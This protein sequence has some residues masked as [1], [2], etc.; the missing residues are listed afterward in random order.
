MEPLTTENFESFKA[1]IKLVSDNDLIRVIELIK[2]E[3]SIRDVG[4]QSAEQ[5]SS[6]N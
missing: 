4:G 5:T 1:D 3:L 6:T 2:W